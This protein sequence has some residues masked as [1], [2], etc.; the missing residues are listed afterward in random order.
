MNAPILRVLRLLQLTGGLGVFLLGAW[1][2]LHIWQLAAGTN[3]E[4]NTWNDVLVSV[5][6]VLPGMLMAVG[7]FLQ[8][9]YYK[10][11]ALLMVFIGAVI[12][13]SFVG[14]NVL[15][16]FAYSGDK[17]GQR[18]VFADLLFILLTLTL[19]I[20]NVILQRRPMAASVT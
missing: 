11:W 1:M 2:W 12:G 18:A 5:M 15:F 7:S 16:L 14:I 6:L 20:T 3:T 4:R 8:T 17:L 13:A 10:H 9:A 19:G